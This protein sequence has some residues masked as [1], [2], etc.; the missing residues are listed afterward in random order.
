MLFVEVVDPLRGR[1]FSLEKVGYQGQCPN[2][3][4]MGSSA[5]Q[6]CLLFPDAQRGEEAIPQVPA[7]SDRNQAGLSLHA[8]PALTGYNLSN[9]GL[10]EILLLSWILSQQ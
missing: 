10:Q 2:E 7:A 5:C 8:F 6:N 4:M 3:L 1:T 9:S